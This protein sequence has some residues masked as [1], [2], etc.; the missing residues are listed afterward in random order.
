L[1]APRKACPLSQV[2]AYKARYEE[3][4]DDPSSQTQYATVLY[5]Q[6]RDPEKVIFV[7][8]NAPASKWNNAMFV[9]LYGVSQQEIG[10][11]DAS[12]A[13]LTRLKREKPYFFLAAMRLGHMYDQLMRDESRALAMYTDMLAIPE[14]MVASLYPD[15]LQTYK[16]AVGMVTPRAQELRAAGVR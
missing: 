5:N 11:L 9:Y 13:T 16:N 8:E 3:N 6:R 10:D 15:L 1:L 12:I 2:L 4:P 14:A 7:F